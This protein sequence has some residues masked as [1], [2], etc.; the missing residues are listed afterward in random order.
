MEHEYRT[1]ART[2]QIEKFTE[3][4]GK[5]FSMSDLDE[6]IHEVKSHEASAIN[7]S[8]LYEQV[9]FLV[10]A[11]GVDWVKETFDV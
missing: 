9:Q 7:N 10:D 8:T 11:L 2:K 3:A 5:K 1:K 4:I 6:H